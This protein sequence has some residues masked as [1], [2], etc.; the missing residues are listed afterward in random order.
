MDCGEKPPPDALDFGVRRNQGDRIDDPYAFPPLVDLARIGGIA[1]GE[2]GLGEGAEAH[3]APFVRARR[4][5][6]HHGGGQNDREDESHDAPA[7]ELAPHAGVVQ[8]RLA[9]A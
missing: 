7:G 3:D 9:A 6:Y 5:E 8:Q 1:D 4:G 2:L